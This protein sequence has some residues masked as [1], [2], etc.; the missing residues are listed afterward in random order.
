[1]SLEIRQKEREGITI[2]ELNGRITMGDEDG[3]FRQIVQSLAK[4]A[5]PKLIVDM[6]YVDYIDSTRLRAV[7]MISTAL[8]KAAGCV[9]LL[10]LNRPHIELLVAPNRTT[11]FKTFT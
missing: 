8:G 11:I 1:M 9:K 10:H 3:K 2:L 4:S 5:S 6:Q 7:V